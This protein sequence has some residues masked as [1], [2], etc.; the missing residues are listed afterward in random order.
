MRDSF[1]QI[2]PIVVDPENHGPRSVVSISND[3]LIDILQSAAIGAKV[4]KDV[5][6][7]ER[8]LE[9]GKRD[10]EDL[11]SSNRDSKIG[12]A[13]IGGRVGGY[14]GE[15]SE[16]RFHH[17]GT[18]GRPD[19]GLAETAQQPLDFGHDEIYASG[20]GGKEL[21]SRDSG[22]YTR[23]KEAQQDDPLCTAWRLPG[24]SFGSK[25]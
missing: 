9:F 12:G 7:I 8:K 15:G 16:G 18:A 5:H 4:T 13:A 1:D 24:E 22:I 17:L 14:I 10:F 2:K 20:I 3:A 11:Y 21:P 6:D 23:V 25:R 19:S